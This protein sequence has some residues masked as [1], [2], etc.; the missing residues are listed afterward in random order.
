MH[1]AT[2]IIITIIVV[3]AG[4]WPA[5]ADELRARRRDAR[6][7]AWTAA[8]ARLTGP[9]VLARQD[10]RRPSGVSAPSTMVQAAAL[11]MMS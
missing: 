5:L 6:D 1:V 7:A 8:R 10:S 2:A 4:L 9:T 3:L 11:M